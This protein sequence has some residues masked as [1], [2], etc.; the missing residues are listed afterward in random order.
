MKSEHGNYEVY[1]YD[2]LDEGHKLKIEHSVH[3]DY[4]EDLT[5]LISHSL[6]DVI[7]MRESNIAIERAAYDK[8]QA[9]VK[10]WEKVAS[11]TGLYDRA[12]MYLQVLPVSHT[13]NKWEKA[14]SEY[15]FNTISNMV[16]K[17]SYRIQETTSWRTRT[18]KWEV[19][20]TLFTNSPE[21]N[22]C[23]RLAG[24]Q[25]VCATKEEAEKYIQGRIKAYA[26]L[27][28]E[29]N[30]VVPDVH[31]A[32]FSV[33]NHLLPGYVTESMQKALD[34][35][36]PSIKGQLNELKSQTKNN[37]KTEP[38]KKKSAPEIE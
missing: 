29:I 8:V 12:I 35:K 21:K 22:N 11:V 33:F 32:A 18:K 34:E 27:F 5:G 28:T 31:K 26:P 23:R 7:K 9:A 1:E 38:V 14:K 2:T 30:P 36:K 19:D 16:Y 4:G 15:D 17:M 6:A 20:W 25:K 10:E 37:S 3:H 24:Q 13:S